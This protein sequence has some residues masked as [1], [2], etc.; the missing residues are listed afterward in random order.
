MALITGVMS[1]FAWMTATVLVTAAAASRMMASSGVNLCSMEA[2]ARGRSLH[3]FT[4]SRVDIATKLLPII[5]KPIVNMMVRAVKRTMNAT[6]IVA[7]YLSPS[8]SKDASL[9]QILCSVHAL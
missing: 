8:H 1:Q 7:L 9:L 6:V 3:R 2:S 4:L 5:W